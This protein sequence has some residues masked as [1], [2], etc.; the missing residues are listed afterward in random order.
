MIQRCKENIA[1]EKASFTKL[2]ITI[3][4]NKS[5]IGIFDKRSAFPIFFFFFFFFAVRMPD[6]N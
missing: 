4:K 3:R 2:Y 1:N 5:E 6:V